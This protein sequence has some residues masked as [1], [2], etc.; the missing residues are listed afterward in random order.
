M[1]TA[2]LER[3]VSGGAGSECETLPSPPAGEPKPL[4]DRRPL[5]PADFSPA[6]SAALFR[7]EG[8]TYV[9]LH[10]MTRI[11]DAWTS[12]PATNTNPAALTL[13]PGWELVATAPLAPPAPG[14]PPPAPLAAVVVNRAA[15]HAVVLIRG[16]EG[17]DEWKLNFG[18]EEDASPELATPGGAPAP[19]HRGFLSLFNQTLPELAPALGRLAAERAVDDVT[20]AGVSLGGAVGALVAAALPAR[21][22]AA[23]PGAPPPRVAAALFAAP[24]PGGAEFAALYNAQV[25]GR[26][27]YY[28]HDIV[29]QIPCAPAAPAC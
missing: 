15:R 28:E 3:A 26:R 7:E 16:T 29:P 2:A 6:D 27:I 8:P 13:P 10:R 23:A 25:N 22:A 14:A 18:Y 12:C 11:F 19:L 20:V 24:N 1:L 4:A 21:L 5:P 17:P 9:W